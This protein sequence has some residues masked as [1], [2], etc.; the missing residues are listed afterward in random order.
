MFRANQYLVSRRNGP[1][2]SRY[3]NE[4]LQFPTELV[5]L[6]E[7]KSPQRQVYTDGRSLPHDPQPSWMGYSVGKRRAIS[8]A[9]AHRVNARH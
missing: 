5:V 1:R 2:L 8:S 9:S 3:W 6:T 4:G 7:T